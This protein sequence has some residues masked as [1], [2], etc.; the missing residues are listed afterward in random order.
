[1]TTL[2]FFNKNSKGV[3]NQLSW[4]EDV[5][6]N[7]YNSKKDNIYAN[8]DYISNTFYIENS[9]EFEL[10]KSK[11]SKSYGYYI[12]TLDLDMIT[13]IS[14]KINCSI[15]LY[16][17][18]FVSY[19]VSISICGKESTPLTNT[20]LLNLCLISFLNN[21]HVEENDNIVTIPIIQFNNGLLFKNAIQGIFICFDD[22]SSSEFKLVND[23]IINSI[24]IVIHGKKYYDKNVLGFKKDYFKPYDMN[25]ERLLHNKDGNNISRIETKYKFITFSLIKKFN[26]NEYLTPNDINEWIN[27]QPEVNRIEFQYK[28]TTPW[29]YDISY[30]KKIVILGINM[31]I[32]PL[33]PEFINLTNILY[34]LKNSK[35]GINTNDTFKLVIK[36]NLNDENHDLYISYYG[37]WKYN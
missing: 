11:N 10:K 9:Y 6:I 4:D 1:M 37:E 14:L 13:N 19:I 26:D 28:N 12:D 5:F 27:N 30:M 2:E 35:N 33:Y 23:K 36:T 15:E 20:N 31:Y 25:W 3:I 18:L 22:S 21:Y 34:Y 24:K 7:D 32:I 16:K 8:D 29:V 17:I